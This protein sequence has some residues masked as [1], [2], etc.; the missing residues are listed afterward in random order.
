MM[1]FKTTAVMAGLDPAIP[2]MVAQSEFDKSSSPGLAAAR[3]PGDDG[4]FQWRAMQ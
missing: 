4:S 3:C 2:V 1:R